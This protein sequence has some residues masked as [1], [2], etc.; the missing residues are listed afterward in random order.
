MIFMVTLTFPME[1]SVD[2]GKAYQEVM[3]KEL[4]NMN[5]IGILH[6]FGGDGMKSVSI[7]E[8]EKGYEDEA[9]KQ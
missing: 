2:V 9:F 1:S 5:E 7:Q 3:A 6:S 8:V 4:P